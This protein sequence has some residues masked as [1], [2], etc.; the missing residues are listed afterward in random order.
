MSVVKRVESAVVGLALLA[1]STSAHAAKP[2]PT[3]TGESS[4]LV[5]IGWVTAGS[6]AALLTGGLVLAA[7]SSQQASETRDRVAAGEI[8]TRSDLHES[9]RYATWAGVLS[10]TGVV[11]I[12]TGVSFVLFAP[13]EPSGPRVQAGIGP[14]S[15][16]VFGAF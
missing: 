7:L 3:D 16:S 5:S 14:G 1:I 6:G 13:D 12:A 8:V 15:V 10:V 9:N 4:P 2:G 11:A